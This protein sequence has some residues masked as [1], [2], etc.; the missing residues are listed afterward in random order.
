M[1][2]A[3]NNTV[4]TVD[5]KRFSNTVGFIPSFS[6]GWG[7][8]RKA[9]ISQVSLS[10]TSTEDA[11]QDAAKEAKA[12]TR[13]QLKKQLI[14]SKEFDAIKSFMGEIRT[15]IY[16]NTVPSFFKE[17][18]QLVKLEGVETI[19]RYMRRAIATGDTV[20]ESVITLPKL[21]EAFLL[22]YP[23]QIE[24]ARRTLEPVGQFNA[25][26]YPGIEQMRQMLANGIRW[27]WI[28]FTVPEGLPPELRQ[29]ETDKLERQFSDAGE[30]IKAA[31]RV[32]F[33]EL[34]KHMQ[35]RLTTGPGEK[36]KVFRDSAIG[37]I[38]EFINTF[39]QR[40][41]LDDVEL[42]QLV[43]KAREVLTGVTAQKLRQVDDVKKTV[44]TGLAD[45]TADL[46]KMLTDQPGRKFDLDDE[47][48]QEATPAAETN[49]E[50]AQLA[51]A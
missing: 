41:L 13:M 23:A 9:N 51:L 11:N 20:A 12:K 29:Q 27:N 45:I 28:S 14:V 31:L 1:T 2:T 30:Q 7:N 44:T 5:L 4:K 36:P 16:A 32:A 46:E 42:A 19:E 47:P 43:G 3:N 26:D 37:N 21:V 6:L 48:A 24:E 15:W 38:Q 49:A 39:N 8:S 17:G 18:F 50:P 22:V 33:A 35:E 10:V 34:I 40:N 25:N